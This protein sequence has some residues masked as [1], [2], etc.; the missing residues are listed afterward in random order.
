MNVHASSCLGNTDH[1][2]QLLV[3]DN[4]KNNSSFYIY[5]TLLQQY[6][7]LSTKQPCDCQAMHSHNHYVTY[8]W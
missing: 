2:C 6:N 3:G 5:S 8:V 7:M 1:S 4:D